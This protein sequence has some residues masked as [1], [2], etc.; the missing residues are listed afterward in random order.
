VIIAT[1][2]TNFVVLL[3]E[4]DPDVSGQHDFVFF[5]GRN[6]VEKYADVNSALSR[7]VGMMQRLIPAELNPQKLRN[8]LLTCSL[9]HRST[10]SSGYGAAELL[11]RM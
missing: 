3:A 8:N 7:N 5:G 10:D 11:R 1:K 2:V 6:F 4:S 9:Y